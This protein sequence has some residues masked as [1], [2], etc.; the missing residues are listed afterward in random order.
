[1]NDHVLL[2]HSIQEEESA[3]VECE[4][5]MGSD[6]GGSPFDLLYKEDLTVTVSCTFMWSCFLTVENYSPT[7]EFLMEYLIVNTK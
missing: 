1:M 6:H 7:L 5:T 4:G 2:C 3:A